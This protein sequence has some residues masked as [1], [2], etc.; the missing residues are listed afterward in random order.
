MDS[1]DQIRKNIGEVDMLLNY[2]SHNKGDI[3][4]YQ[5]FNKA[6]VVLLSTK[7]EVFLEEFIDEHSRLVLAGHTNA[8]ISTELKNKYIDTAVELVRETKNRAKKNQYLRW[9]PSRLLPMVNLY[10]H[11]QV[12][13]LPQNF[14]LASMVRR[15]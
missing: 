13:D 1:I 9:Y 4:R 10:H 6:S 14:R 8:T 15:R 12:H 5:M 11:F 7:F 2:A 3:K